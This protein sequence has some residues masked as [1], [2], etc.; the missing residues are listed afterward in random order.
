MSLRLIN[1][2]FLDA[3]KDAFHTL[4]RPYVQGPPLLLEILKIALLGPRVSIRRDPDM[5]HL[6]VE[7]PPIYPQRAAQV[8]HTLPCSLALPLERDSLSSCPIYSPAVEPAAPAPE[9]IAAELERE[10]GRRFDQS[11]DR[12]LS[13]K[14][15]E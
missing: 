12:S 3:Y 9:A 4:H 14:I 2:S 10:D 1:S 6:A 5:R 11:F 7:P 13:K 15:D 8:E